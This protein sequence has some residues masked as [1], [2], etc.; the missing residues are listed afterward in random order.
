MDESYDPL[1]L[2][3]ETD[4]RCKN[5]SATRTHTFLPGHVRDSFQDGFIGRL[6]REVCM[7][8]ILL[9]GGN[10]EETESL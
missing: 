1:T 7:D 4:A 5:A 8:E 6:L 10:Q 3:A 2:Q 9:V